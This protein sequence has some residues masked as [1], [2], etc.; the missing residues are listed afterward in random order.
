MKLKSLSNDFKKI[1]TFLSYSD[2]S[3]VVAEINYD[4]IIDDFLQNFEDSAY[5]CNVS[6][7]ED[8]L[9]MIKQSNLK[10]I[11]L[12][13]FWQKFKDIGKISSEINYAR[14][15]Y[16]SLDKNVIL[17]LPSCVVEYIMAFAISIWSCVTLHITFDIDIKIP[18]EFQWFSHEKKWLSPNDEK[19]DKD[20]KIRR[21]ICEKLNCQNYNKNTCLENL[22]NCNF[23]GCYNSYASTPQK[24]QMWL[25]RMLDLGD[26]YFNNNDFAIAIKVYLFVLLKS[27]EFDLKMYESIA[28]NC[29]AE[30]YYTLKNIDSCIYHYSSAIE[31]EENDVIKFKTMNDFAITLFTIKDSKELGYTPDKQTYNTL[32][33][34]ENYFLSK[35]EYDY[36]SIVQYNISMYYYKLDNKK[37]A[38]DYINKLLAHSLVSYDIR[39]RGLIFKSYLLIIT[40][41]FSES[42]ESIIHKICVF[43]KLSLYDDYNKLNFE[44]LFLEAYYNFSKGKFLSSLKLITKAFSFLK[45][46]IGNNEHSFFCLYYLKLLNYIFG[47]LHKPLEREYRKL[48]NLNSNVQLPISENHKEECIN[49]ICDANCEFDN[50][51]F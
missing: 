29:L 33:K 5:I 2:R 50:N 51:I 12:H 20:L 28:H 21:I 22:S 24:Q 48:K 35:Q 10:N 37:C 49:L 31:M 46:Q 14:D 43:N 40:G 26:F 30:T 1:K 25:S 8:Y 34:S 19:I 47:E 15:I 3:I 13:G 41:N 27:E 38:M 39:M 36:A 9:R 45:H 16:N 11:V 32:K 42:A 7:C 4:C 44:T 6:A 18:F 23:I 17:I